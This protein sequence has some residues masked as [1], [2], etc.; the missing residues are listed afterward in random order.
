MPYV[1]PRATWDYLK[2][3]ADQHGGVGHGMY[4]R[5]LPKINPDDD[6]ER[7]R[8]QACCLHGLTQPLNE[9]PEESRSIS[10]R[11]GHYSWRE[12]HNK[13]TH[14]SDPHAAALLETGLWPNTCDSAFTREERRRPWFR[15]PFE[16]WAQRLKVTPA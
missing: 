8:Y 2:A 1:I 15:L 6:T 14:S 10:K 7:P 16:E 3:Q 5:P 11:Q 4:Y 13:V 9:L 12:S